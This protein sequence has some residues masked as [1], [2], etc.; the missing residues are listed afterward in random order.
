M[1]I[2]PYYG[3]YSHGDVINYNGGLAVISASTL[4]VPAGDDVDARSDG[5]DAL[6]WNSCGSPVPP[7]GP[8]VRTAPCAS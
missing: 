8:G 2:S 7:G 3:I 4:G 5:L 1:I 6:P